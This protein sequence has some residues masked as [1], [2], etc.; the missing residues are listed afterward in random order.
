MPDAGAAGIAT[1]MA[2][3]VTGGLKTLCGVSLGRDAAG[4]AGFV[5]CGFGFVSGFVSGFGFGFGF[6]SAF[7]VLLG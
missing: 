5:A 7:G 3:F 6:D 4:F 2:G 1:G